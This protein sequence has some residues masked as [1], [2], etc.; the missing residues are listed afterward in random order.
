[1]P[2][3]A[4]AGDGVKRG[5]LH[6][7]QGQIGGRNPCGATRSGE[8]CAAQPSG[9]PQEPSGD[10][11]PEMDGHPRCAVRQCGTE[12]GLQIA[13]L[14]HAITGP[15]PRRPAIAGLAGPARNVHIPQVSDAALR[16]MQLPSART[17]AQ[18]RSLCQT[19]VLDTGGVA[20]EP[21]RGRIARVASQRPEF[22]RTTNHGDS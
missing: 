20:D 22:S 7:E 12:L 18:G 9:R 13:S 16:R 3:A 10:R 17:I 5:K 15:G 6:P 8:R 14:T 1:M 19:T 21:A 11:R 2:S 4:Q